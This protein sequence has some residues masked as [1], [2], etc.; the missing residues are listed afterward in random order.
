MKNATKKI[1]IQF[2]AEA[3]AALT[4]FQAEYPSRSLHEFTNAAV[5]YLAKQAWVMGLNADL[6]PIG[7]KLTE[8]IVRDIVA[9]NIAAWCAEEDY[10]REDKEVRP[11]LVLV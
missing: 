3:Q 6:E 9:K 2:S 8:Y 5:L 7:R 11:R 10:D 1:T 4:N